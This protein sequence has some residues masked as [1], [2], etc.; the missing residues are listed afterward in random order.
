MN[1]LS[2]NC[3]YAKSTERCRL[4]PWRPGVF[5]LLAAAWRLLVRAGA[6]YTAVAAACFSSVSHPLLAAARCSLLVT[7]AGVV[8]AAVPR[9]RSR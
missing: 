3:L 9:K 6:S 1:H 8:F 4:P 7:V 2:V 5:A